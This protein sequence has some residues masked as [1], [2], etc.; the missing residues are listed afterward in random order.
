V[1]SQYNG[2][3]YCKAAH[4]AIGKLNGFT[5]DQILQIRS[6]EAM[7]HPKL[8]AL[9]QFVLSVAENKGR[10]SESVK[11]RLFEAGYNE[12]N[13]IDIVMVIGDKT[14]SNYLHNLTGFAVDFPAAAE[15]ETVT[16]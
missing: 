6:G 1:I 5:E 2:C 12:A 8:N 16:H 4:I 3:A 7:F 10:V 9:A 14:I 13:L 11:E 15:L